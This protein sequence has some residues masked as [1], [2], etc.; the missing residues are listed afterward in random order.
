MRANSEKILNTRHNSTLS[1]MESFKSSV[2]RCNLIAVSVREQFGDSEGKTWASDLAWALKTKAWVS[3][4]DRV[5]STQTEE[6]EKFLC[7]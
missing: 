2:Y 4:E 6:A 1:F 3:A 7:F 5:K